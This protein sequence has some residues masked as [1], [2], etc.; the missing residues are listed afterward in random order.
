[1]SWVY[2]HA[3]ARHKLLVSVE[4]ARG[5]LSCT[6]AP[7][8]AKANGKPRRSVSRWRFVPALPRSVGFRPVAAPP[9][10]AA[11]DALSIQAR[12]QSMRFAEC[13]RCR[14]CWCSFSHTP[15]SCHSR[16]RRKHVTPDPQPISWSS[17]SHGMP[18]RSTKTIPVSAARSDTRGRPPLNLGG[19][20]G[21]SGWTMDQK[22]SLTSAFVMALS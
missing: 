22:S 19:S 4:L 1:M 6:F 2:P 15:A 17:I 7:V 21:S 10:F 18:E 5:T 3:R 20:A 13:R 14:S 16:R 12:L 8:S 11:M 9:F